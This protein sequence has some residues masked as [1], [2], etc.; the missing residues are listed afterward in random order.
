MRR[1]KHLTK[2]DRLVIDTMLRD[3]KSEKEIAERIGVHESTIYR[4]EK[5]GQYMHRNSDYTEELRYSP[6]IA[7]QKIQRKPKG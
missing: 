5:R 1:F 3:G 4:E 7:H 2:A 6:D